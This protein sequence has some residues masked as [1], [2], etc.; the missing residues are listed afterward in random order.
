MVCASGQF[1]KVATIAMAISLARFLRMSWVETEPA[2]FL[3]PNDLPTLL[4]SR[5]LGANMA[6]M[7]IIS[8][9]STWSSLTA[10]DS[11]T[12]TSFVRKWFFIIIVLIVEGMALLLY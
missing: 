5:E 2:Q 11:P 8:T 6:R 1:S 10:V 9:E 3:Q 7:L 12:S 4:K